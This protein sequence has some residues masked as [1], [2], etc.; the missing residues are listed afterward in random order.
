M[1]NYPLQINGERIDTGKYMFH[2]SADASLKDPRTG[3]VV[4]PNAEDISEI[5]KE[6]KG[7]GQVSY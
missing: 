2:L 1:K 6:A 3:F 5:P 7:N 4:V